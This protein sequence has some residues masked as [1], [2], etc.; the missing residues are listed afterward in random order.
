MSKDDKKY[1]LDYPCNTYYEIEKDDGKVSKRAFESL[2]VWL[3]GYERALLDVIIEHEPEMELRA[4]A[5]KKL[6]SHRGGTGGNNANSR[7][8]IARLI[9]TEALEARAVRAYRGEPPIADHLKSN[10]QSQTE[11]VEYDIARLSDAGAHKVTAYLNDLINR[12]G[13]TNELANVTTLTLGLFELSRLPATDALDMMINADELWVSMPPKEVCLEIINLAE[14]ESPL[15]L[16]AIERRNTARK[17]EAELQAEAL[18]V[19]SQEYED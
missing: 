9:F 6:D 18:G 1:G 17:G 2:N 7:K 13:V 12:D 11:R 5:G 10:E 14:T 8:A 15:L 4:L 19:D 16:E 3:T